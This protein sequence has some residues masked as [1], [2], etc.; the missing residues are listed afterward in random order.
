M[1]NVQAN[2]V[3]DQFGMMNTLPK[4]SGKNAVWLTFKNIAQSAFNLSESFD[5]ATGPVSMTLQSATIVQKGRVYQP[6]DLFK[7]TSVTGTM[8]KFMER[9]AYQAALAFDT[10]IM[11]TVL[12]AGGSAQIAGTA[13][14]RNSLKK[15]SSFTFDIAEIR[16]ATARLTGANIP[17]FSD[18]MYAGLIHA[19]AFYDLQG[20]TN[21]TDLFKYVEKGIERLWKGEQGQAYGV[22]LVKTSQAKVITDGASAGASANVYQTPIFGP[23]W[24]GITKF[25]DLEVYVDSPDP[26]SALRMRD[27]IGWKTSYARKE[28]DST[29]AVRVESTSSLG[30]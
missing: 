8:E 20:D 5:A 7:D 1:E 26:T 11:G 9:L 25:Q 16:E 4:F 30:G 10:D 3:S 29:R 23:S 18:G 24:Y 12:S 17:T 28:L 27:R 22:R 6:S 21:F 19:N 14:A 2:L 15:N 13:V